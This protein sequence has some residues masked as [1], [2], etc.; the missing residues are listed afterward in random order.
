MTRINWP[1]AAAINHRIDLSASANGR[2]GTVLTDTGS[3]WVRYGWKYGINPGIAVAISQRECQLAADGS[4]LPTKYNFGG[5]TDPDS[6]Y[7]TCGSFFYIDRRWAEYC[8]VSQGI[9]GIFKTLHKPIYRAAA[10]AHPATQLDAIMRVYSPPFENNWD[11]LWRIFQIVGGQLGIVL[12]HDTR[13]YYPRPLRYRIAS[14]LVS[15]S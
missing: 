3:L 15:G 14:T 6:I 7:G 1:T 13:V 4:K 9:E 5:I 12:A 2:V 11:D 10:K 8:T